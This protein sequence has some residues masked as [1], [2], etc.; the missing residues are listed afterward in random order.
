MGY[1][2]GISIKQIHISQNSSQKS[3]F[4]CAC[5]DAGAQKCV[6]GK[7]KAKNTAKNTTFK[8]N[9]SLLTFVLALAMD[10]T[11]H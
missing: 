6:V 3:L 1:E 9:R 2:V 7:M 11:N 4:E 10:Y 5:I 8:T